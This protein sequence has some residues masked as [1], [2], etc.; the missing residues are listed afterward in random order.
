M[1]DA[2]VAFQAQRQLRKVV[3]KPHAVLAGDHVAHHA[4]QIGLK[5]E[6]HQIHGCSNIAFR[7]NRCVNIKRQMIGVE[8]L[9]RNVKPLLI[10]LKLFLDTVKRRQIFVQLVLVSFP[11]STLKALAVFQNQI[12]HL[13]PTADAAS[14]VVRG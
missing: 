9:H 4:S 10:S 2:V 6:H 12:D 7:V 5:C 8:L 11:Q 3:S 13:L 1:S 14:P